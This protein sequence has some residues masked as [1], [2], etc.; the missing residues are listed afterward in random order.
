M[1]ENKIKER[2]HIKIK[3]L[4]KYL[5]SYNKEEVL[6]LISQAKKNQNMK[7]FRRP[8]EEFDLLG[9]EKSKIQSKIC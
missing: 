6:A 1:N 2:A 5:K 4:A 8:K 3:N 9:N 7:A